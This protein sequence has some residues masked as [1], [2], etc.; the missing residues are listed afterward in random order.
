MLW[1]RS[2]NIIL[3]SDEDGHVRLQE[4][5]WTYRYHTDDIDRPLGQIVATDTGCVGSVHRWRVSIVAR[6]PLHGYKVA[7]AAFGHYRTVAQAKRAISRLMVVKYAAVIDETLEEMSE[8]NATAG[9][10][11]RCTV[12]G[13]WGDFMNIRADGPEL[14]HER[15]V[16]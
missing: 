6:K 13:V 11:V 3:T 15:K 10:T 8:T 4:P 14:P 7:S 5:G 16:A 1:K 2:K 12:A 9:F